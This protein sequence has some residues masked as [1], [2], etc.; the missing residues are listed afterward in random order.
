MTL[1]LKEET[2]FPIRLVCKGVLKTMALFPWFLFPGLLRTRTDG[3]MFLPGASVIHTR[4]HRG[5]SW[6]SRLKIQCYHC[7]DWS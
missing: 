2:A 6:F 4:Q 1:T 5:P 3:A 7:S